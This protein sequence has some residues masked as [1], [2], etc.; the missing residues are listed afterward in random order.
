MMN[1][2]VIERSVNKERWSLINI[3]RV[4]GKGSRLSRVSVGTGSNDHADRG[5]KMLTVADGPSAVAKACSVIVTMLISN[6]ELAKPAHRR[7]NAIERILVL[8]DC[9]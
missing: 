8:V 6:E 5:G 3:R 4:S 9:I 1:I 7:V 2:V